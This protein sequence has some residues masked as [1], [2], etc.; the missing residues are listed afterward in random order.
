MPKLFPDGFP[1]GIGKI[2]GKPTGFEGPALS[3]VPSSTGR[4][5]ATARPGST[6]TKNTILSSGGQETLG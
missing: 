4:A 2:K 1:M 3:G 5:L 6:W